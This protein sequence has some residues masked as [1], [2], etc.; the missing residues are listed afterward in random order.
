MLNGVHGIQQITE[1]EKTS[2]LPRAKL[3]M[4]DHHISVVFS[5]EHRVSAAP[6]HESQ[7]LAERINVRPLQLDLYD[8]AWL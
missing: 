6:L 3:C 7:Y 2:I 8:E 1:A 5:Y 4:H